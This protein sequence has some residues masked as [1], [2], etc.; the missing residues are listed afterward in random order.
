[1][2]RWLVLNAR[3]GSEIGVFEGATEEEALDA[4]ARA[5][6]F[7]RFTQIPGPKAVTAI[8]LAEAGEEDDAE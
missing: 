1:M 8:A 3:T 7:E 6:G 4:V 5:G 2:A